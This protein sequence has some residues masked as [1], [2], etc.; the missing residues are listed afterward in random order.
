MNRPL[1]V[2][3]TTRT[4]THFIL[5]I[6]MSIY[7]GTYI[8]EPYL[9]THQHSPV[10]EGIMCYTK[11]DRMI[12]ILRITVALYDTKWVVT[13]SSQG[14]PRELNEYAASV[15]NLKWQLLF[16]TKTITAMDMPLV[17]CDR[18]SVLPVCVFFFLL[19]HKGASHPKTDSIVIMSLGTTVSS[20]NV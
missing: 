9:N 6:R 17:T 4:K 3:I 10:N 8:F 2:N 20:N 11:T 14:L 12:W 1:S 16:W 13:G 5:I 15:L 19:N 7:F 18:I